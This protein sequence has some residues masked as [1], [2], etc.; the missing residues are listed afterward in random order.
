[1]APSWRKWAA[2]ALALPAAWLAWQ[3]ITLALAQTYARS[4]PLQ[5]LRW[6]ADFAPALSRAAEAAT[7]EVFTPEGLARPADLARRAL[8][9]SPVEARALRTLGMVAART[10]D[11]GRVNGLMTLA[12]SRSQR[13]PVA[14]L[15]LFQ[16]FVARGE[17]APAMREAD[18]LMRKPPPNYDVV[19]IV[20]AAAQQPDARPALIERMRHGP[21]WG[22]V[23]VTQLARRDPSAA[24]ELLVQLSQTGTPATN[25]QVG[26][27]MRQMLRDGAIPNAYLAW[28]ALLPGSAIERLGD[29][30]DPGFDGLPG[31]PPFNW[32]LA[33]RA[34]FGAE[35]APGP[36]DAG[37]ALYIHYS[38]K[39]PAELASEILL[40]PPGRYQLVSR[41]YLE[42]SDRSEDL[43]WTLSC[44]RGPLLAS[45]DAPDD[46]LVW[47]ESAAASFEVPASGC[48]AQTLALV[49][50]PGERLGSELRAWVDSVDVKRA[51]GGEHAPE[52]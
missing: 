16:H 30:Y 32:K 21:P 40:L 27:L 15:W 52:T 12:A 11:E 17:W 48:E 50:R 37:S 18:T 28:T 22:T 7:I 29:V 31:A 14:H 34:D 4:D 2:L 45:I 39:K 44:Y 36:S 6:R 38:A 26:A 49:G 25:A 42:Q 35:I 13:D 46:G 9:R 5:A 1:M 47:R 19:G 8:L 23:L 51:T 20:A 43:G 41:M 33:A 3:I 10:H 24:F